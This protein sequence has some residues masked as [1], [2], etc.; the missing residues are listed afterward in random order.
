MRQCVTFGRD[1]ISK[2]Y[3]SWVDSVIVERHTY[4]KMR[5]V[6]FVKR[7]IKRDVSIDARKHGGVH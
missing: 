5:Q 7:D 3:V 4:Y 6:G 1:F 2:V